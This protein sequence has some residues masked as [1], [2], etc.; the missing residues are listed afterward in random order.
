MGA[1]PREMQYSPV[2]VLITAA[3]KCYWIQPG[4]KK[5]KNKYEIFCSCLRWLFIL[6]HP[7]AR[8][9]PRRHHSVTES[10]LNSNLPSPPAPHDR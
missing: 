6:Y 8:L 1:K 5:I 7:K 4:E 9:F 2:C 3:G 10:V